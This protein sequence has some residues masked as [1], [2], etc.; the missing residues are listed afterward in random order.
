MSETDSFIEEVTE[1]VR[2]DRLYAMYR[3]YGWIAAFAVLLIVGGAAFF[4]WQKAS[5]KAAAE[6]LGDAVMQALEATTAGDRA[7]A[8]NDVKSG[9]ADA[10]VFLDLLAAA[11]RAED[12][13]RPAALDLLDAVAVNPNAPET[14]RQ[15]AILKA[16]I[17]RGADQDRDAR[18]SALELLATP[19]NPFRVVALEQ[20]A[21]AHYEFGNNA[22]AIE[23][24]RTILDEPGATQGLLQRAQQLIVALGGDLSQEQGTGEDG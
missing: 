14:Y 23:T 15:L 18:M 3:K 17:L 24:L 6:N 21:L 22:D 16:V 10:D 4:E 11:A 13:D 19:G 12:S 9:N 20:I 5:R 7:A 2:R 1:E 8:L